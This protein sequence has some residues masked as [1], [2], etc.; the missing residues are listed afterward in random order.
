MILQLCLTQIN[1]LANFILQNLNFIHKKKND[2]FAFWATL[3]MGNSG[4]RYTLGWKPV[5][6]FVIFA[7][8][9]FEQWVL[10]PSLSSITRVYLQ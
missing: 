5:V 8:V 6:I 2:K 7:A 1:F 10:S 4:L 3:Y 9:T